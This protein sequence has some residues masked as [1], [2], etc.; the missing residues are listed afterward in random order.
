LSRIDPELLFPDRAHIRGCLCVACGTR[1]HPDSCA[2]FWCSCRR[3][4]EE[5]FK[6]RQ[7]QARRRPVLSD[8]AAEHVAALGLTR[9]ALAARLH[10]SLST[11]QRVSKPGGF[12]PADLER[13]VLELEV[14]D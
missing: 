7:E 11:A 8:R 3:S 10:C 13:R 6:K 9:R 12:V 4:W 5:D 2:C 14:V 1:R